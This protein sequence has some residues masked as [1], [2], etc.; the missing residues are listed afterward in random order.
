MEDLHV[1]WLDLPGPTDDR[2]PM[3]E[4]ADRRPGMLRRSALPDDCLPPGADRSRAAEE[5]CCSCTHGML[6]LLG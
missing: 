5:K 4:A 6:R 1:R 3:D 2:L